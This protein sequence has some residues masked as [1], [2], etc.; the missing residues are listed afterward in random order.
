MD[1]QQAAGNP[2]ADWVVST[3]V[4]PPVLQ[5]APAPTEENPYSAWVK[6]SD[7]GAVEPS[8]GSNPYASWVG[9][10]AE[11]AKEPTGSVSFGDF[12]RAVEAGVKQL[13]AAGESGVSYLQSKLGDEAGARANEQAATAYRKEAEAL[14]GGMSKEAQG[15]L[16]ESL[17]SPGFWNHPAT[18]AALKLTNMAPTVAAAALPMAILGTVGAG[19]GAVTGAG[20][21]VGAALGVGD[22]ADKVAEKIDT[23]TDDS[24]R[25]Q[26]EM[27]RTLR[28]NG[29]SVEDA[30]HQFKGWLRSDGAALVNAAVGG[31][32]NVVGLPSVV[33]RTGLGSVAGEAAI[34]ALGGSTTKNIIAG[35]A[36]EAT[37]AAVPAALQAGV[38]NITTQQ[39]GVSGG[40]Q[41]A[42]DPK[43]VFT[44]S[45]DAA[46]MSALPGAALG[47]HRG[48]KVEVAAGPNAAETAA[49]QGESGKSG[50]VDA[51]ENVAERPETIREQEKAV[52]EKRRPAVMHPLG[53]RPPD[54]VAPGMVR[55]R[56]DGHIFDYDPSLTTREEIARH[57]ANDSIGEFLGY[58]PMSK[59]DVLSAI[60]RGEKPMVVKETTPDGVEVKTAATVESK[61]PETLAAVKGSASP[62]ST[63]EVL[64]VTA[65]DKVLNDRQA[66][67]G[68]VERMKTGAG[69]MVGS[70]TANVGNAARWVKDKTAYRNNIAAELDKLLTKTSSPLPY[71]YG[72]ESRVARDIDR[73]RRASSQTALDMEEHLGGVSATGALAKWKSDALWPAAMELV[74]DARRNNVNL[75]NDNAHLGTDDSK[76]WRSR[77]KE[78]ELKAKWA[79]LEAQ[80]PE[81]MG[82]LKD[83]LD[84]LQRYHDER[85]KAKVRAIVEG[86]DEITDKDGFTER[87]VNN[88]LTREER[89]IVGA[90]DETPG[91]LLKHLYAARALSKV[92]G[93]YV[94]LSRPRNSSHAVTAKLNIN[95]LPEGA[96]LLPGTNTVEILRAPNESRA[97]LRR[98]VK[99]WV[100]NSPYEVDDVRQVNIDPETRQPTEREQVGNDAFHVDVRNKVLELAG[101]EG[102]ARKIANRL[103][104]AGT[105]SDISVGPRKPSLFEKAGFGPVTPLLEN[106]IDRLRS[107]DG[108]KHLSSDQREMLID[109]L[110]ESALHLR[111]GAS[112]GLND[113]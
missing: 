67:P 104:K 54:E 11:T 84:T 5:D 71:R 91:G 52:A 16:S 27:Y 60:R 76:Y 23:A 103:E 82:A 39:A 30:K 110:E 10:T 33:S 61:A 95:E 81:M 19:A 59:S 24:L 85:S 37:Q 26:S 69:D 78:P 89:A 80:N 111:A 4:E 62:D 1:T 112:I 6:P 90:D 92:E 63:V 70:V 49:L 79:E 64:P 13:Q 98:R 55:T 34:K 38:E 3:P 57:V 44:A 96:R 18:A 100:E 93:T 73:E 35:A 46:G 72:A 105:Y 74:H 113:L 47:A 65:A 107:Q 12:P 14:T 31:L 108:Y 50:P 48:Y 101:S 86:V 8:E 58:G 22:Y 29:A 94:P 97:A 56:V 109:A 87:F 43:E 36:G 17:L 68:V 102:D 2:Y 7:V 53:T 21:L 66:T 106:L 40:F 41:K 25:S 77:K 75:F 28:D 51:G 99:E 32:T 45:V 20:A 9:A 88:N 42:I 83:T 15:A